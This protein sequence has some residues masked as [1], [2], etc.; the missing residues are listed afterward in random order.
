MVV[1]SGGCGLVRPL[2]R[3]SK[4]PPK[5]EIG[6]SDL[7]IS[8]PRRRGITRADRTQ[9]CDIRTCVSAKLYGSITLR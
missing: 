9:L 4:D 1:G 7:V 3:S 6:V 5:T 2:R 8:E